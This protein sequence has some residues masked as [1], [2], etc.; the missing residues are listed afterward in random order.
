[1]KKNTSIAEAQGFE[2]RLACTWI[3]A[4]LPWFL[5]DTGDWTVVGFGF[6]S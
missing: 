5:K 1:L 3:Y 6:A 2:S 4:S